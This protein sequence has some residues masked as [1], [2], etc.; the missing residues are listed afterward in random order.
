LVENATLYAFL[1]ARVSE[2]DCADGFILDGF[3]GS[4]EKAAFL[5][6]FL[7][8]EGINQPRVVYLEISDETA[9]E[10][11]KARGRADD[12]RGFGEEGLRQFRQNIGPLLEHYD[13]SD[14]FVVD[15]S[16]EWAKTTSDVE[17][18]LDRD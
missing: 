8:T 12:R 16:G 2:D 4:V 11:M 3:P 7:S 9:L 17:E 6:A 10:R 18:I 13:G 14:L 15:S 5:D 1:A